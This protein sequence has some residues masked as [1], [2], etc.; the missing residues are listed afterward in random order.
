MSLTNKDREEARFQYHKEAA[1]CA[2]WVGAD[3]YTF[4]RERKREKTEPEALRI[5]SFPPLFKYLK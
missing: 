5:A 4:M 2:P 1:L 3:A